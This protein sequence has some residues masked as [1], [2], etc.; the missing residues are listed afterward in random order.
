VIDASFCGNQARFLNH[1]CEPNCGSQII[2]V[3][4]EKK[5]VF[6]AK[7]DIAIG[8]EITYDYC[9]AVEKD[10]ITCTCGAKKCQGRLN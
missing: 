1:C 8:T 4:N 6:Y 7:R 9:F 3:S 2:S 10:K 5:I